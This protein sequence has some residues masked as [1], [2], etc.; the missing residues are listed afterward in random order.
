MQ[1]A[2]YIT[3]AQLDRIKDSVCRYCN[4]L[5][6]RSWL[7]MGVAQV[8][9]HPVES[10]Y[11]EKLRLKQ[12]SDERASKWPNTIE[13]SQYSTWCR[14]PVASMVQHMCRHN[15]QERSGLRMNGP[16]RRRRSA[17]R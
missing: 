13:V 3:K 11:T 9:L 8:G 1:N 7:Y 15:G 2:S 17:W 5:L 16:L 6:L 4:D 10:N 12:L 14:T